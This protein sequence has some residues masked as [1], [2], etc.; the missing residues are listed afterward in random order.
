MSMTITEAQKLLDKYVTGSTLRRH[1]LTVSAV[2]VYWAEQ[3]GE[4]GEFWQVTGLL[5]DLDFE[6]YPEQHCVKVKEILESERDSFPAISDELIHAIQSHGWKLCC[7]LE[8]VTRM[9]K[10]LYTIDE[11]TGLIFAC[12]M[13]RPSKSVMDMEL[14]SVTKKF[15]TPAFAAG[16]N[17]DVIKEGSQMLGME[18]NDVILRCLEGMRVRHEEL[19]V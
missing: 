15:K 3:E 17:R 9:E 1:C 18:L 7:D 8:P 14:K 11:L 2:M 16:C 12:A 5:H 13:A 10:V 19:G 4:D 6:K